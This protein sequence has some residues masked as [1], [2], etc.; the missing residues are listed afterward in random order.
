MAL[1]ATVLAADIRTAVLVRPAIGGIDD[2]ALQDLADAIA[3]A[4]VAHFLVAAVVTIPP[5]VAV[6]TTGSAVAQTGATVAPA[7]GAI[8]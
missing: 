1:S 2:E 3:G 5:G 8:T 7:I 6:A 4:V